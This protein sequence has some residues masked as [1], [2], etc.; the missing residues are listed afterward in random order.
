MEIPKEALDI[1]RNELPHGAQAEIAQE[2]GYTDEYVNMVLNASKPITDSN[3][4][5]IAIA[6]R[7]IREKREEEAAIQKE[8]DNTIKYK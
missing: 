6:Q 4:K 3:K 5:I 7:K 1:I 2:T 8:I